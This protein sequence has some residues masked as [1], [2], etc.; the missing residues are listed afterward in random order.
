MRER[1]TA[2]ACALV[3]VGGLVTVAYEAGAAG[4]GRILPLPSAV[5]GDDGATVLGEVYRQLS[6]SALSQPEA[7]ALLEA[8]VEAMLAE[9]D[10]P[11]SVF[12]DATAWAELNAMLDG[13]FSG[14]GL[15]LEQ[16]PE[17]LQVI[18]VL[19]GTPAEAAGVEAGERIVSV[20]GRDVRGAAIEQVVALV[21]GPA[22]TP[23]TIGF[24]GGSAGPRE[25]AIERAELDLPTVDSEL[26]DDGSGYLDVIGF[27]DN[28]AE[29]LTVHVERLAA[30]GAKGLVLDLRGNPGGLLEEAVA[31]ANVFLSGE[32][33]VSVRGP[34]GSE[35]L[36]RATEAAVTDL[37]MVVLVD[38][39]TASAAEIVAAAIQDLG[40]GVLVGTT[41]FGK[42]TVQTLRVLP[43]GSGMKFTTAEYFTANG[44]S[45]EGTGIDPDRVVSD[46]A[47]ALAVAQ[48][49]LAQLIAGLAAV[50]S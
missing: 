16:G 2:L 21:K 45:I 36:L 22:G 19:E 4:A 33:I 12:Y 8:A 25:L 20:N 35:R 31:V 1:L 10:D 41:T 40:R 34:Q 9:L 44:R 27:N 3:L 18:R 6:T 11:Y 49:E 28:T 39:N 43:D 30:Q 38:A 14:V 29:Q 26:L 50:G 42:G 48:Q 7:D 13:R 32:R 5:S 23:V 47:E 37:P 15:L 17:G 24:E 46:P